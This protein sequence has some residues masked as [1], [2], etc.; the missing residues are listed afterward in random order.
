LPGGG[1]ETTGFLNGQQHAEGIGGE[2]V[3]GG[4]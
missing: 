2:Q 4:G 1:R 3:A